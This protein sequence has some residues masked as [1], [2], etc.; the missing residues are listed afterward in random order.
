[1]KDHGK[2]ITALSSSKDLPEELA[3]LLLAEQQSALEQMLATQ[4]ASLNKILSQLV[5]AH[6]TAMEEAKKEAAKWS[7]Q[8]EDLQDL[9]ATAT[10][11][12]DQLAAVNQ[13]LLRSQDLELS[14]TL[15]NRIGDVMIRAVDSPSS[16][17]GLPFK[18]RKLWREAKSQQPPK[19]LGGESFSKVL[20]AYADGGF[21][22]VK[23]LLAQASVSPAVRANGY[24]ALARHLK[25]T[26]PKQACKA[27]CYA[28]EEDPQPFRRK[29]LAFRLY[30]MGDVLGADILL[31]TL[32]KDG[33]LTTTETQRA[34]DIKA[35]AKKERFYFAKILLNKLHKQKNHNAY[36]SA[37][38]SSAFAKVL[39]PLKMPMLAK[40]DNKEQFLNSEEADKQR[41]DDHQRYIFSI[42]SGGACNVTITTEIENIN[43]T[44][45]SSGKELLAIVKFYDSN[46]NLIVPHG[47]VSFSHE[48][49]PY[50]YLTETGLGEPGTTTRQ[51]KIPKGASILEITLVV[52]YKNSNAFVY[53]K[54]SIE[55]IHSI[56][57][58]NLF[59]LD[60]IGTA[61]TTIAADKW[62]VLLYS[63]NSPLMQK[64]T[65]QL[66]AN[67][68]S[69]ALVKLGCRVIYFPAATVRDLNNIR[70]DDN[71]W[72]FSREYIPEVI[73]QVCKKRKEKNIFICSAVP[74]HIGLSSI[75]LAKSYNWH[76][77]YEIRDD[78]EDLNRVGLCK[79][80]N[81]ILEM[82]AVRRCSY[83]TTVSP[84]L[85][86][87]AL[88]L[89]AS[90]NKVKII[91]NG[92]DQEFLDKAA[93]YRT[94]SAIQTKQAF[95]RK[96]GY[97]G[98]LT[99]SW[100]D[101]EV[102]IHTAK[103]HPEW[104]FEMI[105]F[106]MPDFLKLSSNIQIV[107][108]VSRIECID[109][110]KHWRVG[111]IPFKP[112]KLSRAIDPL[113]LWEYLALG[114]YVLSAPMGSVDT[115]PLTKIYTSPS[116]FEE[117]LI[118]LMDEVTTTNDIEMLE[119]YLAAS[120][121]EKRALDTL[122]FL[123]LS[124]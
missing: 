4:Q 98:N 110:A 118:S 13:A 70:C 30:E 43:S 97:I 12:K 7:S 18:L 58:E 79:W 35:L 25:D 83:I 8:C 68:I 22:A 56:P 50:F 104:E 123:G 67:H 102:V 101:W 6:R 2:S 90:S 14:N 10:A 26:D 5:A 53:G 49:G 121:W 19:S 9:L 115:S 51:L 34:R 72:Q 41:L 124:I 96:I 77:L 23:A 65:I 73:Y 117:Q 114:L 80:Y 108:P 15:S 82:H 38:T 60:A 93:P 109:I 120:V 111:L 107:G 85:K 122:S 100:F 29:W 59:I 37:S 81:D 36:D 71:L 105:G 20:A 63:G 44:K 45:A 78:M 103:L 95:S 40:A 119:K 52:W 69:R 64:E 99:A 33:R 91:Q 1:M 54:P 106:G 112:S 86:Q 74:D 31:G 28:Y 17:A 32:K 94:L 47:D 88:L 46:D 11:E 84:R 92:I 87:K 75:D 21:D 39:S 76:T 3:Q 16:I 42:P 113:K 116:N 57:D 66:R 62:L 89:G 27:A 24:T 48:L 55:I 61:I